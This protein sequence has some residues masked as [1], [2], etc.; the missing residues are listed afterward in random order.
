MEFAKVV[1][2]SSSSKMLPLEFE[3]SSRIL[4]SQENGPVSNSLE[5]AVTSGWV[6]QGRCA[7]TGDSIDATGAGV[8]DL[9]ELGLAL[10]A[11]DDE[12][13]PLLLHFR[14]FLAHDEK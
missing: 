4:S 2:N 5:M 8:L 9:F 3:R 1:I 14:L 11:F 12:I 6:T 10:S 13:L 7:K